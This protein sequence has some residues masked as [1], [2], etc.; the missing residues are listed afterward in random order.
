M[1]DLCILPPP[2]ILIEIIIKIKWFFIGV[3][4]QYFF[5]L[6]LFVFVVE[7]TFIEEP[8]SYYYFVE[9]SSGL[10]P[11]AAEVTLDDGTNRPISSTLLINSVQLDP[12]IPQGNLIAHLTDNVVVGL[13]I[14]LARTSNSETRV[15]CRVMDGNDTVLTA[16]TTI[17]VGE[18]TT[19]TH[20][21]L[22]FN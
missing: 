15:E 4:M 2:S 11:C 22:Y 19:H 20:T 12:E 16:V 3:K 10:I 13:L 9:G 8:D 7:Y 18:C 6:S 17:L 5:S 1:H 14:L 21:P